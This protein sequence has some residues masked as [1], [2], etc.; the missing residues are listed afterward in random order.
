MTSRPHDRFDAFVSEVSALVAQTSDEAAILARA[1]PMLA[2]LVGRDDWLPRAY[3][4]PGKRDYRQYLLYRDA[5]ARFCVVSMAWAPGQGTPVHD[6][7]VWGLVGMLRGAE[8]CQNYA[9]VG[10]AL[11]PVGE[12]RR[13]HPGDVVAVSPRVGDIHR[14]ANAWHDQVSV[15]IHVYGADIGTVRRS[16][17]D[18]SGARLP[19][20]SGY[21]GLPPL[22]E[23]VCGS[24]A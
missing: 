7:T 16:T 17:F 3:A 13:L 2:E 14:V 19:F 12:A 6:H 5:W 15:S 10:D 9:V 8:L 11:R 23:P 22:R 21:A 1:A 4:E 20:V 24:Y 18:A